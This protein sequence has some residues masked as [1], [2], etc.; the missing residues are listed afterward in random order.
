MGTK[1]SPNIALVTTPTRLAGLLSKFG[2]KGSARFRMQTARASYLNQNLSAAAVVQSDADFDEYVDE[3]EQYLSAVKTI[4]NELEGLGYPV[5]MVPRTYI[6]N[7]FFE[8]TEAVVVIGPDGLVANTAKYAGDI[9]IIGVN[10]M[11]ERFDGVLLPFQLSQVRQ[12]VRQTL[13]KKTQ[14]KHVTLGQVTLSD[15]QSMLAFNDFFI[16]RGSHVSARYVLYCD[17]K[18]ETQSSSGVI[19][20]TGAGSTGWLSSVYHMACGVGRA[21]GSS[22]T[23]PPS[24]P[25]DTSELCWVVREPFLSRANQVGL[26][27]GRI[28]DESP[29]RLESLMP[30]GGVIFS[31]GVESDFLEFNSGTIAE[32]KIAPMRS[33]LVI[34]SSRD[35]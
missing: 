8:M 35:S 31:D 5:V 14:T 4:R 28:S 29:L 23:P 22:A 27:T 2:T 24:I 13:A 10:P 16:G 7:F 20:S 30:E 26:V 32:V 11:P 9:P 34:Q 12:I 21:I 15:G 33:R 17:G 3:D 1:L 6:A 18:Q 19:I 25:W